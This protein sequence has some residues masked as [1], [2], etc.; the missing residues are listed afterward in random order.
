M[1][2][3]FDAVS[4][5]QQVGAPANSITLA[6][7]IGAGSDMMLVVGVCETSGTSDVLTGVTYN[8]V[9]MTRFT[10][11]FSAKNARVWM[12]YLANPAVGTHN[13][14][15]SFSGTLVPSVGGISYSGVSATPD[16][17]A[18]NTSGPG[19]SSVTVNLTTT[20]D[21]CWIVGLAHADGASPSYTS[22]VTARGTLS[23]DNNRLA[24]SNAAKTPPGS[25]SMIFSA[26]NSSFEAVLVSIAPAVTFIPPKPMFIGQ[27]LNRSSFY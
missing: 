5:F 13:I 22:G 24:D 20:A 7:T 9:A 8:G 15:A 17:G 23:G 16:G 25:Y 27:A 12:Y 4:G 14:V 1:A 11:G 6:H 26:T 2:I 19:A 10:N 21:N 3:A 18:N